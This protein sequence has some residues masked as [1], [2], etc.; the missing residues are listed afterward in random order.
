MTGCGRNAKDWFDK[1][2]VIAVRKWLSPGNDSAYWA[3]DQ[4]AQSG[5]FFLQ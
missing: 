3:I 4:I 1:Y 2:N 5:L